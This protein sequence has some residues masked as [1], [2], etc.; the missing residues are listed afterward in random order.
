MRPL[1]ALALTLSL[2]LTCT[3]P[4][5][6]LAQSYPDKPIRLVVPFPPGGGADSLARI[7][8]EPLG[9]RLGQQVVID[10]K[11]GA[12]GTLG[13][14]LVAHAAPDGYTLLYVTPGQQ[15]VNPHLMD[16]LPYDPVNGFVAICQ[17]VAAPNV[18]VVHK[19]LPVKN[20]AEL[21]AYA[22]AQ[23]GKINFASSG[24]GASSHLAGELFKYMA[25]VNIIH[26][27][28][29]GSG[30]AVTDVLGGRVQMTIDTVSV[31]MQHIKAGAVRALGVSSPERNPLLPDVPA[32]AETLPG[33][34]AQAV[35]YISAPA[36]TP[37]AI[38]NRLS[39]EI[40][41]VLDMPAV[42]AQ[43]VA[44]GG[45]GLKGSTPEQMEA[46]VKSESAK[47]KKV[48]DLS[49]AKSQ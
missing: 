10:N 40:N 41:A 14:D 27:P 44:S 7:L 48:I 3:L 5:A 32:I 1:N 29:K 25:G 19:D 15:M 45:T 21:I 34:D 16:K 13:A 37:K 49:G 47:W 20:I 12:G 22:K 6:A 30:L 35:N 18:L 31:Y 39:K 26:V 43:F 9:K 8:G 38:I 33:F 28:Y 2:A 36:G 11:G 17:V 23:P 4:H 42:Q 24:I 46:L